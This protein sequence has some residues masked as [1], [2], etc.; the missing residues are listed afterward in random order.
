MWVRDRLDELFRCVPVLGALPDGRVRELA[1]S[2][3]IALLDRSPYM[4]V[5]D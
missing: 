5:R 3:D 4:G 1:T 2:A